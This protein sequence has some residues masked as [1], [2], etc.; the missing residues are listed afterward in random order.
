M[1]ELY[2]DAWQRKVEKIGN[3]N[4]PTR[5]RQLNL[6]GSLSMKVAIRYDGSVVE[7]SILE[8]SGN[9]ILDDAALK[10]VRLAAPFSPLPAEIRK[11]TDVLEIIRTWQFLPGNRISTH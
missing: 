4:Y 3:L 1:L 5:A 9:K 10:I 7:I 11:T 6:S 2:L 8:S